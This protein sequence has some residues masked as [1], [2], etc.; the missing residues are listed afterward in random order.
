M[1]VVDEQ[2]DRLSSKNRCEK[3]DAVGHVE[4][5]V[6]AASVEQHEQRCEQV[7]GEA[8]ATPDHSHAVDDL[9]ALRRVL[10]ARVSAKHGHSVA[11]RCPPAGLLEEVGLRILALNWRCPRLAG[12]GGNAS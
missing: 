2:D 10:S 4:H 9:V 1:D 7:D 11:V 8:S 12:A 3:G 6:V 5:P